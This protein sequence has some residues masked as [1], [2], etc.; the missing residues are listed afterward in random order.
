M[1]LVPLSKFRLY[2]VIS[3]SGEEIEIACVRTLNEATTIVKAY[4]LLFEQMTQ[5]DFKKLMFEHALMWWE[6]CDIYAEGL[7][8]TYE[9]DPET[10]EWDR[11]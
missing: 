7:D 2:L 11:L 9:L 6:G 1:N 5:D 4:D 3:G 10:N 8:A